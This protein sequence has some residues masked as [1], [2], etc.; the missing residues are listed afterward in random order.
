MLK[1]TCF[2]N[3]TSLFFSLRLFFIIFHREKFCPKSN[4]VLIIWVLYVF[5]CKEIWIFFYFYLINIFVYRK[6]IN[7]NH[8]CFYLIKYYKKST[9]SDLIWN[10]EESFWFLKEKVT[11]LLFERKFENW[12]LFKNISMDIYLRLL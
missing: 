6:H 12:F 9:F 1:N 5:F 7:I 4:W 3:N 2:S 8:N 11:T 10:V